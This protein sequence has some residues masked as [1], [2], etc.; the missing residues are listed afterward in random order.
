MS[1]LSYEMISISCRSLIKYV[2]AYV[3]CIGSEVKQIFTKF[4]LKEIV[5][6]HRFRYCYGCSKRFCSDRSAKDQ[7][8]YSIIPKK[9][10]IITNKTISCRFLIAYVKADYCYVALAVRL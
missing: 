5:H 3:C 8:L 4:K 7:I 9:K 2:K 1:F 6:S 10:L